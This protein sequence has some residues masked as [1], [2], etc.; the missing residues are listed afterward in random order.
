MPQGT[1]WPRQGR[2]RVAVRYG[3]ALEAQPA[4]SAEV[5]TTRIHRAVADLIDEDATTWWQVRRASGHEAGETPGARW[6][7]IWQQSEAPTAGGRPRRPRIW[8]S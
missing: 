4:E 3:S 1:S 6:R 7:R 2:P 8:R 5:F